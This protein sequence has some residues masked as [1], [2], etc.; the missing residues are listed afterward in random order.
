M[1]DIITLDPEEFFEGLR[2]HRRTTSS[3]VIPGR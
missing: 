3:R 2:R 1:V